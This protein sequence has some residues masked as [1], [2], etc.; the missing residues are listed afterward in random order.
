MKVDADFRLSLLPDRRS[1][2]GP[3]HGLSHALL[4][5]SSFKSKRN[6]GDLIEVLYFS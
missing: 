4:E 5:T 3:D 2:G 1:A 6:F